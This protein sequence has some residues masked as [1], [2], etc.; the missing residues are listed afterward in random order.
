PAAYASMALKSFAKLKEVL[1]LAPLLVG[2]AAGCQRS[3]GPN[4]A[5]AGGVVTPA[6]AK[7]VA[8]VE[9][10]LGAWPQTVR[11]QGSLLGDEDAR[12][13]SKFA[14]RVEPGAVDLGSSVKRGAMIVELDRRELELRVKQAEAQRHQACAAI[15]LTPDQSEGEL[16]LTAAPPVMLEQA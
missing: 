1:A 4:A 2:V 10:R 9:A 5:E 16:D 12:I 14:G 13:G 3:A 8:V 6:A 7:E 11:I 15:G